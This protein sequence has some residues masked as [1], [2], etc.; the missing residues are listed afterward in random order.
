M[1]IAVT[2]FS[3]VWC[4]TGLFFMYRM[5]KA[6]RLRIDIMKDDLDTYA[7]LPSY[8]AMVFQFWRPL[9]SFV[10][11]AVEDLAEEEEPTPQKPGQTE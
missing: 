8:G 4:L 7:R 1:Q 6:H 11:E 9:S 3:I 5:W 10:E 2:A